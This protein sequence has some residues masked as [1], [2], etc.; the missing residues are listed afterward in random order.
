MASSVH[1]LKRTACV[2]TLLAGAALFSACGSNAAS[3]KSTLPPTEPASIAPLAPGQETDQPDFPPEESVTSVYT[4]AASDTTCGKVPLQ[5]TPADDMF[6]DDAAFLG[7]SLVDGF[8]LY[9]G[10]KTCDVYASTSM[11]VLGAGDL[12]AQ[13]PAEN[14]GK[15]YILLGINEIG[16]DTDYFCEQY[17]ALLDKIEASQSEADIYIMSLTPV[18]QAK[19]AG[20]TFT[21]ERINAYNTALLQLAEDR[22]I[23]FID[24]VEAM[25]DE[26][27]YL[28]ADVTTDGVHFTVE[29]YQV[30]LD[31]LRTHYAPGTYTPV[32]SEPSAPP[33][34]DIPTA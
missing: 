33:T 23:W 1:R 5:T 9:S 16:Y 28:P 29:E 13:M 8:R 32:S 24:L 11:T 20:G 19:S 25:A 2:A 26:A 17:A 15:V 21:M 3:G 7:N 27:G 30:W 34:L 6:F 22:G 10:L 31:C 4:P 14:Y 18:S 12:V